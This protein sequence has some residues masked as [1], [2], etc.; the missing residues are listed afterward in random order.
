MSAR[1]CR[2]AIR[3]ALCVIF[4][5]PASLVSQTHQQDDAAPL[6]TLNQAIEMA[7][8]ENRSL[9]IAALE[10]ENS[11]EQVSLTRIK[12]LPEWK[13]YVFAS[14]L[15]TT[16]DFKFP[17]GAFGTFPGIG[18]I[19]ATNKSVTTPRVF[20]VYIFNQVTQPLSQLYKIHLSLRAN[21][22][23]LGITREKLRGERHSVVDN[24]KQ[25]YYAVLQSE[26]SIEAAESM[27]K[28]Y[29][30]LD[31]VLLKR[32]SQEASL[33][34]DSLQVKAKLAQEQ[35]TLVQLRNAWQSRKEDLND[36]LG[37]DIRTRF[38]AEEVPALSPVEMDLAA[39][40]SLAL[41][42]RPEIKQAELTERQ[43]GYNRRLA[44]AEYI[45]DVDL[46]FQYASNF[47]VNV[48]PQN[49]VALGFA[50]N[51]QPFDWGKRKHEISQKQIAV[52]EA[53]TQLQDTQSKVL[54]DVNNRFRKLQ[55]TRSMLEAAQVEQDWSREKLRDLTRQFE[56][57]VVLLS[58][59]LQ[60]QAMVAKSNDDY[61]QALLSF[62]TAKAD[63]EKSLGGD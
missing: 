2:T 35:Y 22:L 54:L 16:T 39:A 1:S 34:S 53:H 19:P 55:E 41:A 9:K 32:V 13:S 52:E 20:N 7:L 4:F 5:V 30:E 37:R 17:A 49:V 3:L 44:K 12:R 10:V 23:G 63:F 46:G 31:R 11:R 59:V 40:Q 57:E 21:E 28:H 26:S 36:L 24:V 38:R 48:L 61:A 45:P 27:L 62:W 25:A 56:Q 8:S 14:Q 51:Y 47:N 42:Q 60:G 18:P 33:K 58:D 50:L 15:L 43:A 6:L 29:Q